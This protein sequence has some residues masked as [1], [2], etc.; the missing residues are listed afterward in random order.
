MA[1]ENLKPRRSPIFVLITVLG[2]CIPLVSLLLGVSVLNSF[3]DW[4]TLK[5]FMLT[6]FAFIP[7]YVAGAYAV[8]QSK[9]Y[10]EHIDPKGSKTLGYAALC[11]LLSGGLAFL[12]LVVVSF[13]FFAGL[14]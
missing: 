9:G 13:R 4:S 2:I 6:L 8:N 14:F 12:C 1:E 5:R 11:A 3:P 7:L 10:I